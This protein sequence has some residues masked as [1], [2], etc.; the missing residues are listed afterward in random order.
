[1]GL[2]CAGTPGPNDPTNLNLKI[3]NVWHHLSLSVVISRSSSLSIL[4]KN[5]ISVTS[6][7]HFAGKLPT[8]SGWGY[9]VWR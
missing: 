9:G 7:E 6:V 3:S 8:K 4:E 5:M 1:M 2:H